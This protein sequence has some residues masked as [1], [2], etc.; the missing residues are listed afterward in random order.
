MPSEPGAV[1]HSVAA[2]ARGARLLPRAG[3]GIAGAAAAGREPN[4]R[5]LWRGGDQ[6]VAPV[7]FRKLKEL[8]GKT[9]EMCSW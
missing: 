8:V 5:Q 4:K 3:R 2:D 1:R 9:E 7:L 6:R